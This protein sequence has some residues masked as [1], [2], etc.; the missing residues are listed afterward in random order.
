MRD[1]VTG[2]GGKGGE[3]IEECADMCISAS[4]SR[5]FIPGRQRAAVLPA[6]VRQMDTRAAVQGKGLWSEHADTGLQSA[7]FR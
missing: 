2:K 5:S 3:E 4:D 6:L 1:V 7:K